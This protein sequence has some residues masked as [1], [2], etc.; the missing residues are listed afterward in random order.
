MFLQPFHLRSFLVRHDLGKDGV[1]AELPRH[2]LG[3]ASMVAGE[4]EDLQTQLTQSGNGFLGMRLKRVGY[5][6]HPGG[7]A[8]QGNEHRCLAV[9][10]QA[11]SDFFELAQRNVGPSHEGVVADPHRCRANRRRH[12]LPRQSFGIAS[13]FEL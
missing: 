1:N 2:G 9:T 11:L 10:G 13:G 4:H 6:D 12:P 8:V 5:R 7:A 3:A